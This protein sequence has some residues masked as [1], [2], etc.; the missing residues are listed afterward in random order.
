MCD[1]E[2]AGGIVLDQDTCK[3]YIHK[4]EARD[5][6]CSQCLSIG[7]V[8]VLVILELFFVVLVCSL[9]FRCWYMNKKASM[10]AL[11]D[12]TEVGDKSILA[13][14]NETTMT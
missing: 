5:E 13:M 9:A 12:E 7:L 11:Q 14:Y 1:V 2:C 6:L 4:D 8:V 10:D 3:C